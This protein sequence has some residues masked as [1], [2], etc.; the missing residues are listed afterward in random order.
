M[1]MC[2]GRSP[3]GARLEK[4]RQSP[5]WNGRKFQNPHFTAIVTNGRGHWL[6]T[7]NLCQGTDKHKKPKSDVPSAKTSLKGLSQTDDVVVWLG[8]SSLFIQVEGKRFLFDPVLTNKLPVKPFM[9]PF[10]GADVYSPKDIPQVDYLI[11][12][13]DHWDHLD[14]HTVKALEDSVGAVYCSLGIGESF[15]YWGYPEEK[16]HDMDWN[17]SVVLDNDI[18]LYCLPA[19]HF[20]RRFL[21]AGKTL[22]AS[23]LIE[24]PNRKVFVS[25]DGGYDTHFKAI[26]ERFPAIDLAIMENGQYDKHWEYLH[27]L[28]SELPQAIDDLGARKV[29]TYHNSKFALASHPWTEPMELIYRHSRGKPWILLTPRIGERVFLDKQ[30]GFLPWWR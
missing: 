19:R 23:Y 2:A 16:I 24:T 25:G 27:T 28:P 30:Q 8:H 4:V 3:R 22:W 29:I 1:F 13:H 21:D 17:D 11:I 12:T 10:P 26:A 18:V 5:Q 20:S 7:M 14:Y 15:A 9:R 6:D